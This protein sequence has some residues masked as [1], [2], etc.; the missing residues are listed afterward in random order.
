MTRI[1][2]VGDVLLDIDIDGVSDRLTP[3]A[4]VPVIDVRQETRRAGGAGLVA[5]M[6]ARDGVETTLVTAMSDDA[7]SVQLREALDGVRVIAGDSRAPTP[8]KTR[9]RAQGHAVARIDE[10][11]DP[12]PAPAVTAEMLAAVA[13]ADAIVVADY[14]RGLAAH[15]ALRAALEAR[16]VGV[17][18]VWDPHPRG[19][20]PVRECTA[21]T[22][23]LSEALSFSRIEGRGISAAAAAAN[24]LRERWHSEHLVVTLGHRGALIDSGLVRD[25]GVPIVVPAPQVTTPDPCG[26]GD[27]FAASVAVALLGG[28]PI[29]DAVGSGVADAAAF[30]AAGGVASP[31]APTNTRPLKGAASAA[32]GVAASVRR[33]GG[34]VVAT[35]GCFD[36]V[37]AGHV[38][39]LS[40]ARALGDCLIV[41]LNSD[42][43]VRRLKGEERP[44]VSQQD[45]V[46]LLLALESVDAVLVFDEDTPEQA[47]RRLEPDLWVKGGD[48]TA[49][50]LPEASV[51]AEWGGRA[52]TVP[53][54]PGR[55]TSRLAGALA[56]V[57]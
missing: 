53:F 57:G 15:P 19:A 55:S 38:R 5:C 23:N 33:S 20:P 35:G 9:L 43:S 10:G 36:L 13:S 29:S 54:H 34:T 14:G 16:H 39:T 37:H 17:P 47:I 56:R 44:I 52:V 3:D 11:C 12:A 21:V 1:T 45:R 2:V 7:R 26:A 40:A 42:A 28:R 32:L 30:L 4:P 27:R 46:D 49:D 50:E 48:Y 51:I 6:L 41:C 31:A 18:L 25:G 22:P 24:A 8:V